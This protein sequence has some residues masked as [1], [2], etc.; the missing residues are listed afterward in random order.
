MSSILH[1]HAAAALSLVYV[2]V[3][4]LFCSLTDAGIELAD[5]DSH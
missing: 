5:G 3:F 4:D 2:V 1:A